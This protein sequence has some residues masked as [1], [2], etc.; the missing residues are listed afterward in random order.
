MC[1]SNN[2]C[3]II[4]VGTWSYRCG[5]SWTFNSL[6]EFCYQIVTDAFKTWA[7]ANY[8]CKQRGGYLL[9]ISG[10]KEQT[11]IQGRSIYSGTL[12][13]CH[14]LLSQILAL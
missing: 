3:I 5:P 4:V 12:I 9:S 2:L 11:F 14:Y 10:P 6:D 7:D 13:H 1:F 8:D